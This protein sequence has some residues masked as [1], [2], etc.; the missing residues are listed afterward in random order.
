MIEYVQGIGLKL[1]NEWL[2][3]ARA[4]CGCVAVAHTS[5]YAAVEPH[6]PLCNMH[7]AAYTRACGDR[8]L[9]RAAERVAMEC[10]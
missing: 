9:Q 8:F 3:C 7:L 5:A 1:N 6:T 2:P 10:A 4:G